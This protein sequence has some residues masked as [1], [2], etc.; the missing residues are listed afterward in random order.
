MR[1][2]NSDTSLEL[3]RKSLSMN[4]LHAC[5]VETFSRSASDK[6]HDQVID[7]VRTF[8]SVESMRAARYDD[9]KTVHQSLCRPLT[10]RRWRY[11]IPLTSQNQ[12][13]HIRFNRLRVITLD[14]RAWPERTGFTL[15]AQTIV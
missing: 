10:I 8:E 2:G 5:G 11:R 9:V 6:L 12:N 3:Q 14:L 1:S 15:L 4:V 13:R 7:A